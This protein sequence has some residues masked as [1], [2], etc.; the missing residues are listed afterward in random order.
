MSTVVAGAYVL[1]AGLALLASQAIASGRRPWGTGGRGALR[2]NVAMG[3]VALA[4]GATLMALPGGDH[5]PR[6]AGAALS[7][8]AAWT[9]ADSVTSLVKARHHLVT[10]MAHAPTTLR[11]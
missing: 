7:L 6:G 2:F 8:S 5:A 10:W 9:L 4:L 1:E 11:F 3:V